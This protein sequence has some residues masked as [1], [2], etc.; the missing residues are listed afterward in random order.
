MMCRPRHVAVCAPKPSRRRLGSSPPLAMLL[1]S[2]VQDAPRAMLL[3]VALAGYAALPAGASK[4]SRKTLTTLC[5]NTSVTE[6]P[7]LG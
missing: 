7:T 4:K 5:G 3:P 2:D 6:A 1:M